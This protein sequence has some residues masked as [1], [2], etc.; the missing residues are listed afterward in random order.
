MDLE[1]VI[2]FRDFGGMPGAG[3]RT[4]RTGRLFRSG[5]F[6]E[7]TWT[8]TSSDWPIWTSRYSSICAARPSACAIPPVGRMRRPRACWSTRVRPRS[9]WRLIWRSCLSPTRRRKGS[10]NR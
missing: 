6:A 7:A 8:P 4:V 10:P 3:G 9:S 1:G 2:N 5:H